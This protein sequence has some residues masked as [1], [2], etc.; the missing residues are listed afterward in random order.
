MNILKNLFKRKTVVEEIKLC[1]DCN[2]FVEDVVE[3]VGVKEKITL[4]YSKCNSINVCGVDNIHGGKK[5]LPCCFARLYL[6]YGEEGKY[7]EKKE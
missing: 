7:W 2:F 6:F 4:D 3:W 1:K 5:T